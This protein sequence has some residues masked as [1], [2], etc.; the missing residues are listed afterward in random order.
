[1]NTTDDDNDDNHQQVSDLNY[2]LKQLQKNFEELQNTKQIQETEQEDLLVLLAEKD[3]KVNK[4]KALLQ[5]HKIEFSESETE[6]E[7]DETDDD[8]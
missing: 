7:E 3:Q 6:S 4:L 1:M 2:K 8:L 5:E